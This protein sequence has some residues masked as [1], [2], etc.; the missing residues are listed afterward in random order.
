MTGQPATILVVDDEAHITHVVSLKL[1]NAGYTVLTAADGEEGF[2]SAVQH[3]PDLIITDLQMPYLTGLEMARRLRQTKETAEIPVI[4][5]T[6]RG[7]GLTA[8]DTADANIVKLLSKPFGPRD[9]LQQVMDQ[10]GGDP[11]GVSD[12]A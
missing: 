5:L 7:F 9:L 6:A 10:L 2:E 12:A 3:R 1:R 8:D 4:I 11:A